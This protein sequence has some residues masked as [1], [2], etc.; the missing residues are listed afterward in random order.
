MSSVYTDKVQA[1]IND[2]RAGGR[3]GGAN[4]VGTNGCFGCGGVLRISLRIDPAT[5][6]IVRAG[7]QANGCGYMMAAAD[8]LAEAIKGKQ[9]TDLHGLG[10][11]EIETA[12]ENELGSFPAER[13][14]CREICFETLK[15]A[16]A[17]FR[18]LQLESF[19]G[20]KALICTCFG[21]AEDE[22]ELVIESKSLT[23]V[24]SVTDACNAG[25][26]CGSCRPLIQ[27]ILDTAAREPHL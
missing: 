14:R 5:K 17:D 22:V 1:R 19:Q 6:E 25:G 11:G 16:L 21:V 7:F 24:E 8:V 15:A 4:A 26:G 2:L 9:L 27:E 12:V 20:D 10:N 18:A 23:T 3:V 13:C